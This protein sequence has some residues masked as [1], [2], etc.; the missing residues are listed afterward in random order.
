[1]TSLQMFAID[2]IIIMLLEPFNK[3]YKQYRL[4]FSKILNKFRRN[5]PD[6]KKILQFQKIRKIK[7]KIIYNVHSI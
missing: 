5:I 2:F 6:L 3:I 4:E 7:L 1:M